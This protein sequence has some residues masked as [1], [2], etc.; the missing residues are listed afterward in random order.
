MELGPPARDRLP[1]S[2]RATFDAV[3]DAFTLYES[4]HDG[5]A[6]EKLQVVGLSSPFLDW[7]LLLRGLISH[8]AGD[9]ARAL[10]NWSRLADG[11]LAARLVAPMRFA[12]EPAFRTT[13]PPAAQTTLQ[14][15]GDRL[16]GGLAPGLR[17]LQG[18][19]ARGRLANA[20][21]QAEVVLPELKRDLPH[22]VGRLG[23]CFRAAIV[24]AGK[25]EDIDHYV[26]V[27][28]APTDDPTLARL[29]ALA[30]EEHHAWSTAHKLWQRFEQS[31]IDNP[32]WPAADRDRARALIWCRMG[33]NA[34][35]MAR[36]GRRLQPNAEA[37]FKLAIQI[38]PDLLEPYEQSFLMLRDRNRITQAVAAGKRL[39]K[40]FPEHGK[41]L[42][43]M[44]ELSQ[45]RGD[46]AAAIEYARQALNANP[47]DA[48]L[49]NL[50][51]DG[52][53]TRARAQAALGNLAAAAA[54]LLEALRLRD[55]R[56]DVGL[57]AQAAA[58]AFKAGDAE[59]A[60][61][62]VRAAWAVA[63]AAAA[64]ALSIEVT[65]LKLP[66]PLKQRFDTEFAAT[67][68]SPPTGPAAVALATG[69]A[70]QSR[71]GNYAGQKAHEKKVQAFVEAAVMAEPSESDLVRLCE[72]CRDLAWM[73]LLKKTAS[74]GQ[75]RF[76][77]NPF[78][79][80]FEATVHLQEAR[81][82]GPATWRVE[83][84]LEKSRRLAAAA[85]PDESVRKLL[86]D[87]DEVQRHMSVPLPVVHMLNELFDM[88]DEG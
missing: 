64:Y 33:R 12:L 6:R 52:T 43:A 51:A 47:L 38:A 41:A 22:A 35:E 85:S 37:C 69:F 23:D 87:L 15:Q 8:A 67:L 60:E 77:A 28:G 29:G 68:A 45:G 83:P 71:Q 61:G 5:A 34:E 14:R 79:P 62:H 66:K 72:R 27:F 58:V 78:F 82:H 54:D 3:C 80:F 44:A 17:A 70:D 26:R 57:L 21:H 24:A 9:D 42:E 31:I 7:K 63:P 1:E 30:S 25:P 86:C 4:G 19:L 10:D 11:R 40:R 46:T 76:P 13:H 65:R 84:L 81:R 50:L 18:L 49:R 73:R 75:K 56:P 48:R 88:F 16:V 39:L 53:R 32:A 55:G 2:L 74:R 59:T 36:A 20:F